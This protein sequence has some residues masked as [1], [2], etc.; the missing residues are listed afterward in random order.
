MRRWFPLGAVLRNLASAAKPCDDWPKSPGTVPRA[1][2]KQ[3]WQMNLST[4]IM[5]CNNTGYTS[6][7]STL[8]WGIIDFDWSNGKGTGTADGWVKHQPMDDEEMLFEQ[9]RRTT[10]ASPGTTVWVYR[11]T[12]RTHGTPCAQNS[13]RPGILPWYFKFAERAHGSRKCDAAI[14]DLQRFVP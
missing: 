5:P 13:G 12:V 14:P 11:N 10:K 6:P 3:T 4:I 9:V 7:S 2:Y 8:G 1:P